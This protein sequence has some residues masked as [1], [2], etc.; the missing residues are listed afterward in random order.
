MSHLLN[1]SDLFAPAQQALLAPLP[2]A[3]RPL[4]EQRFA[5][6]GVL[7]LDRLRGLY[8]TRVE[9]E[10]WL[11][12][13]MRT[14]GTL[15]A[16]RPASL[17]QLDRERVAQPDW[18]TGQH[19]LGYSAYVDRFA[20]TLSGVEERI[21]Y[22]REL[23]VTYLHLLPFLKARDG[24]NDGG[25]AVADFDAIAPQLGSMEDLHR[26]TDALR[27]NG[28][29]L[30]ADLVLNHVADQ[31]PWAQAAQRGEQFYQ[32]YFHLF[33]DRAVP[34]RYEADL[35]QIF[36]QAAPGN[37]TWS[38]TMQRWVW[39]TF[40]AYQWDLNYANP[41][42]FGSM[43]SALLRLANHGI[44]IFRL[45]STAFLWKRPGTD[46]M[47]QP[48]T[49]TILQALRAI[50]EI[51]APAVLLK[52]E[53]IVPTAQLPAYFGNDLAPGQECHIAY[54]SS[55]MAAGW[56]GIAE[57]SAALPRAV[58]ASTPLL[59]SGCSWLTYVRCHDDISWQVLRPDVAAN[60]AGGEARLLRIAGFFDGARDDGFAAGASF[61]TQDG[62]RLHGTNGMA[63]ALTGYARARTTGAQQAAEDRLVLLYALAFGFGALPMIYMGDELALG[64]DE[65]SETFVARA[66]DGRWLQRPRFDDDRLAR[67]QIQADPCARLFRRMRRLIEVRSATPALAADQPRAVLPVAHPAV[68]V[69]ARGA[70]HC[71]LFNFSGLHAA[72]DLTPHLGVALGCTN[73]IDDASCDAAAVL[74]A[75]Y[76]TVWLATQEN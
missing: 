68:L 47:N 12:T 64:N 6:H 41:A 7:L 13:L 70:R 36:P 16:V 52:A 27:R 5:R 49:H 10:N 63:A 31:H 76:G 35:R 48:E 44:E 67:R 37:F 51:A 45:D 21:D 4:I 65:S 46:C 15:I 29:S 57:Q 53:A 17:C 59:P 54:H 60:G 61:Q 14:L 38:A 28:I 75:P 11:L 40:Y 22:L 32:D 20:G 3:S 43:A 50:V 74:L 18:F 2:A 73:L 56:A 1:I 23:G 62:H 39:T 19:V 34:D 71:L 8:G 55:L 42:V 30:C 58:A 24:D 33:T 66:L 9:F 26:L 72:V 69:L 25:F